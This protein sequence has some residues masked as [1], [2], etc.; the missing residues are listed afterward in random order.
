MYPL[1]HGCRFD[2]TWLAEFVEGQPRDWFICQGRES[3]S[4]GITSVVTC[5]CRFEFLM[6]I[7]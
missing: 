2:V 3:P 7:D 1:C 4:T 5:E 6:R